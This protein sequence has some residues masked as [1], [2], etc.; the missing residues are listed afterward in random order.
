MNN[1]NNLLYCEF[2]KIC[3]RK[4]LLKIGIAVA[5]IILLVM[6]AGL[7]VDYLVNLVGVQEISPDYERQ[8]SA[9]EAQLDSIQAKKE[10]SNLYKLII[11]NEEYTVRAQLSMYRYMLE[12][13]VPAGA[14][15]SYSSGEIDALIKSDYYTF[16]SV[17][18]TSMMTLIIVFMIVMACRNTVGEFN[19]GT[20]KMQLI[21]PVDRNKFFTAKWLS[22]YIVSVGILLASMMA[23]FIVGVIAF[24]GSA[25]DV[26]II[27]NGTGVSRVSPIVAL[28]VS[29][30]IKCVRLFA[31]LQVTMFVNMLCKKN[32]SAI[33]LNIV[34][35]LMGIGSLVE[36][37]AAVPY[38]G[39][40]GFF[41]NV[42]WEIALGLT[43]P[44]IRGL[45]LW[46]M[47]PVTLAWTAFF[48]V[49]S[50]RKFSQKEI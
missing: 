11:I 45:T 8:I 41:L 16:T 31:I 12:N 9:L 10:S 33:A 26:L 18:A 43:G 24:G 20:M 23:S 50:Y 7:F 25:P 4:T 47:I 40:V 13:N 29:F 38:V 39:F 15:T 48:M 34:M 2:Y 19:T 17:C 44:S 42:D 6:A 21:R 35:T 37:I 28:I 49:M 1:F 3:R 5:V 30:L 32:A 14:V 36:T 22:V 46:S 27:A